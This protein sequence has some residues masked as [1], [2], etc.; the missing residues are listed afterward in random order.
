MLHLVGPGQG[1]TISAF[2]STYTT[3]TDGQAIGG[4]YSLV[5]EELWG[6]PTPL[7]L[8]TR[9]EEAFYVLS[10]RLAVWAEGTET[11][12]EPGTFLLVPPGVAHAARRVDD[13]PARMLTLI[14]PAGLHAFFETVVREGEARLSGD[15]ERL[16]AL[17]A[18]FGSEILGDYPD[19]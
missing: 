4:A 14:S 15:P 3:K 19:L 8:H 1:A 6:D 10:G 17:A 7:H 9:E 2:G 13:E 5:E 11:I 16:M 12:A 18:Q